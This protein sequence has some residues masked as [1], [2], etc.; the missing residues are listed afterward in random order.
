MKVTEIKYARKVNLG[1]YEAEEFSVTAVLDED[2]GD[3][4]NMVGAFDELKKGVMSAVSSDPVDAETEEEDETSAASTKNSPGKKKPGPKPKKKKD[5]EEAEEE[6]ETEEE[7]E[8]EEESE[9]EE[10]EEEEETEEE[11]EEEEET[12]PAAKGKG[13]SKA[14][15]YD[16]ANETHKKLFA[17]QLTKI[18]AKWNKDAGLKEKAKK[19]SAKLQGKDFMDRQGNLMAPFLAELKKGMK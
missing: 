4:K 6:E 7:T 17:E 1:N 5:E 18:N 10:S 13:K 2:E 19:M 3:T 12:K 15:T 8:A 9:E 14:A 11:A 16:R